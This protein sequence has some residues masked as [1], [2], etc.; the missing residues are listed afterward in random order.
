MAACVI[1]A[2]HVELKAKT[3]RHGP[4]RAFNSWYGKEQIVNRE[5]KYSPYKVAIAK[6]VAQTLKNG[7][8]VLGIKAPEK[9]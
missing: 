1:L 7:L 4:Y 5:D 9:M 2:L 3:Y 8:F 6:A